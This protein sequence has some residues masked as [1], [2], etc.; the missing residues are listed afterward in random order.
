MSTGQ[1][2]DMLFGTRWIAYGWGKQ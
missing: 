2:E 1:D